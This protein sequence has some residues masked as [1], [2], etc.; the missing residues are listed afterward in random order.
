MACLNDIKKLVLDDIN[1][2]FVEGR[3]TYYRLNED[4]FRIANQL[5]TGGKSRAMSLAQARKIALEL[6]TRILNKY[7]PNVD[8]EIIMPEYVGL[9]V[10]MKVTPNPSYLEKLFA[11]VKPEK[12]TEYVSREA[13][14]QDPALYQQEL[15]E[16]EPLKLIPYEAWAA[17]QK[18][19]NPILDE[20][21]EPK[22]VQPTIKPGVEELF[23]SNPDLAS[24]GTPQQYSAYLDT[25]FP[26]SK[27]KDIVYHVN[28]TGI[29][30]PIDDKAFYSTDFGSWLIELEEMKGKRNPIILN[31]IN[32]TIV[33]EQYEFSD[34]AKKFRE[35]GL[36][37]EFVTPD[38][39]REQNTDSVIGRDSGQGGNEKTYIT[40]KADQV[41]QLGSKQD[42]EGFKKFV[43][44]GGQLS[45]SQLLE[46][47][48]TEVPD[49]M[50]TIIYQNQNCK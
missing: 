47:P 4:T 1:Q 39:V 25:I 7:G 34:K 6:R 36:G 20:K 26:D 42:I 14:L 44:T 43:K 17:Q 2:V 15:Q 29:I 5:E 24:V 3:Y 12:R 41:Y 32:P 35:S 31:I 23:D 18:A 10:E 38:E 8:V 50:A 13:F 21:G 45:I 40:Y 30:S 37:D 33:D 46:N 22:F 19:P 9:P 16:D 48:I 11:Q 28:K 27:V 49:V